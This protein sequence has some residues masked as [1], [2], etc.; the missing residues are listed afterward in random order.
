MDKRLSSSYFTSLEGS[1]LNRE[2]FIFS[3]SHLLFSYYES[4]FILCV[5]FQEFA[6][7]NHFL[8]THIPWMNE[9]HDPGMPFKVAITT[10]SFSTSSSTAT[11]CSFIWETL[12]KYDCMVSV[13][14]IFTFS[15]YFLKVI[16]WF[17]F[18]PSNILVKESNI[19]F[20]FF[21]KDTSGIRWSVI[22]SAKPT[23][24]G[25]SGCKKTS[26]YTVGFINLI[27]QAS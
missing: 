10:S 23:H 25:L 1:S 12:V 21:R 8:L 16:L 4:S 15:N 13:F 3:F 11:S 18:F 24:L 2:I 19:S 27:N 26:Q 5:L 20:G 22:E 6:E 17:M 14:W 7:G 9:S